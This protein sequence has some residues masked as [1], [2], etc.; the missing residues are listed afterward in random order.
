M[1]RSTRSKMRVTAS[2]AILK[3]LAPDGGLFVFDQVDPT[4]FGRHLLNKDYLQLSEAVFTSLL[5]DYSEADIHHVIQHA[6]TK[7]RFPNAVVEVDDDTDL[8][9]LNLY[10]GPTF[11]FKD[12]ALSVLPYLL[13]RAKKAQGLREKTVVL[14]ATSGDTGSAALSGFHDLVDTWVVVM[15]PAQGVSDFQEKQ[16]Q[17]FADERHWVIPI[18]G[19]FDD[20]QRLAKE[21]FQ[22]LQPKHLHMTSANSINIGRIV[23]QTVYYF[24]VYLELARRGRISFGETIDV[25]VPTGNF[26]NIYAGMLA[27]RMGLPIRHFMIASNEN[28][29]LTEVFNQAVYNTRRPLKK[30]IS[31]SMDI[32]ISSNLERYLFDQFHEDHARLKQWMDS[33]REKGRVEFETSVKS[34]DVFADYATESETLKEIKRVFDTSHRLID[35]HTA[36]ASLV[37][38]R[39]LEKTNDHTYMVVVSTASPYKFTPAM[40]DGLGLERR[41]TLKE[42]FDTLQA[43]T[44][45]PYDKRMD[46]LFDVK[47]LS[48]ALTYDEAYEYIKKGMGDLDVEN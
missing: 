38:K 22:T 5:D 21:L 31:P 30:T 42:T 4:F 23:P 15:Y 27:K 28:N 24:H 36:V 20:C 18:K 10:L 33:L 2:E 1:L 43:K 16:M 41:E 44:G 48:N 8:A 12:M 11:A 7:T 35:P 9:Y 34:D 26:G 17:S 46:A 25:T 32:L 13:D 6:Y 37:A 45:I 47:A 3:G 40:M 29:V 19:N 39:H 14:T